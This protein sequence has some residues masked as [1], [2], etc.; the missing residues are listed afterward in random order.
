MRILCALVAGLSLL[1]PAT[2]AGAADFPS[3][4]IRLI[5]PFPAGGPSDIIARVLSQRM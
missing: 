4:Q 1:L 2:S 5:V 3:R